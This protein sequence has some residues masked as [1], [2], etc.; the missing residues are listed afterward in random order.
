MSSREQPSRLNFTTTRGRGRGRGGR[1]RPDYGNRFYFQGSRGRGGGFAAKPAHDVPVEPDLKEGLDTTKIIKTLPS[2]SRPTVPKDFPIDNV[3]YVASYNWVDAENPT[4]VVPGSPAIWTGRAVPFTLQPDDGSVYVDQNSRQLSQYP[5]LPL[6][7]AADAIHDQEAPPVDWPTVDVITDRNGLRKLLRW[8]NPSS[9]REV[10]DFRID[11]QLVGTKTL[12]LSR[13]ERPTHEMQTVR[14]YGHAFEAAMTRAAPDCPSSGHQRA[15]TYDMF[16]MK[17][18]V[19]FGVDACSPSLD[20]SV[21][22][23]SIDDSNLADALNSVSIEQAPTSTTTTTSPAINIVRAGTQVPQ[24]ALVEVASRSVYYLDQH[25]WNELYPQ[26]ALSQTPVFRMGV[27]ERGE[28][29]ELREW[30]LEGPGT[31]VKTRT[32]R[33]LGTQRGADVQDLSAQRRETAVQIMRLARV[34]Q[35]VQ[36]LAVARGTGPEGSFGLVCEDGKL[37]VYARKMDGDGDGKDLTGSCL[38]PEV[39]A[40]FKAR[41]DRDSDA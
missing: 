33:Q 39:V 37:R 5:M 36:K 27:H 31:P 38:P 41:I 26:L 2:P 3:K 13:W 40:R 8:L 30:Q 29:T 6:F 34:L 14:S 15:I 10:R 35:D 12:V 28:F 11:V 19:R 25:D 7:T 9:G 18:I 21:A 22:A 4:M 23:T 1:L 20:S 16:G 32:T 24:D 17:M